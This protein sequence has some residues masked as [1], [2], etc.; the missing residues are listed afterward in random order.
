VDFA[1][2]IVLYS[3]L[4]TETGKAMYALLLSAAAQGQEVVIT[5]DGECNA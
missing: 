5:G 1:Y 3:S 4:T 2:I